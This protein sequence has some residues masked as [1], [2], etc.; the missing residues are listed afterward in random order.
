MDLYVFITF[1]DPR[2][3]FYGEFGI[4]SWLAYGRGK[5]DGGLQGYSDGSNETEQVH[6]LQ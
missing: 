5:G 1:S 4:L 2:T 3:A 6:K